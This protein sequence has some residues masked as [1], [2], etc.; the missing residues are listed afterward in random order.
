MEY[1]DRPYR[2]RE[3]RFPK[4]AARDGLATSETCRLVA[5]EPGESPGVVRVDG[6][7]VRV[8]GQP[9]FIVRAI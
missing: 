7:I 8:E 2:T 6:R 9:V 5:A 4:G 3:V 1:A